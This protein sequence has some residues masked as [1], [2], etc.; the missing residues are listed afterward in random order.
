MVSVLFGPLYLA[1]LGVC[2]FGFFFYPQ[3]KAKFDLL[4]TETEENKKRIEKC[5]SIKSVFYPFLL[6]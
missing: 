3:Y 6:I 4:Y 1:I 2:T 5:A